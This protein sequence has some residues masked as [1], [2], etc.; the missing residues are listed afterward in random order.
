[1]AE[2][3]VLDLVLRRGACADLMGAFVVDDENRVAREIVET[4]R[5]GHDEQPRTET[6]E[7]TRRNRGAVRTG[8]RPA[9]HVYRAYRSAAGPSSRVLTN[10]CRL[11]N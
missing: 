10:H 1:M 2:I 9:P 11:S 3:T 8:G 4:I 5:V 6:D 7:Q